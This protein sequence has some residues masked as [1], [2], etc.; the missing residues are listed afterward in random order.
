MILVNNLRKRYEGS[1]GEP[2]TLAVDDVSLSVPQGGFFTLLGAS[3]CGKTTTLRCVA[4]LERPG[5]GEITLGGQVVVG[6]DKFVPTERRDLGM[7]FQSYAV[8]PHLSVFE[9]TAFPLRVARA[10]HSE[11]TIRERVREALSLVGL[12]GLED[13]KPTQLSGGQQQRLSLA[14]A[15][16]H[17]PTC[18]LFDEPLSNLDAKL[19]EHMRGE[20]I[21]IQR[22]LG[23]T[24][25]YVTHDQAEALS[26][27]DEI[28]VMHAGRIV[29]QGSPRDVYFSPNSRLVAEFIGASNI[30]SGQVLD[31]YEAAAGVRVRTD[32]GSLV[33][34]AVDEAPAPGGRVT[35]S[36]RPESIHVAR[37]EGGT[38][39]GENVMLGTV[40]RSS[41]GG[42]VCELE[43]EVTG[44]GSRRI[45]VVQDSRDEFGIGD[46]VVLTVRSVDCQ[47]LPEVVPVAPEPRSGTEGRG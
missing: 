30:I 8:W 34:G 11:T 29:Q 10:R 33:C 20:I 47:V 17:R 39:P 46:R 7:V 13:R 25:L 4:G 41:F 18:L 21:E 37:A 23:F 2:G 38:A 35:V 22:L 14:R 44:S 42:G 31:D 15:L 1:G 28:A 6:H 43:V 27:S 12:E 45:R 5:S 40:A 3:G 24:A 36:I 26:M 16:V 9:N 19:R 32:F